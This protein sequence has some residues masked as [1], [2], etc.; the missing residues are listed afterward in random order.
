LKRYQD[1]ND[2]LISKHENYKK[3]QADVIQDK[4][5][6]IEYLK[7]EN[8][9]LKHVNGKVVFNKNIQDELEKYKKANF[10]LQ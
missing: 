4:L 1:E 2:I 6:V 7:S 3:T 8:E 9:A 10:E 5:R